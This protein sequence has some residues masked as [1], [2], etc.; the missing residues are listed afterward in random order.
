[1][2]SFY[3]QIYH[4]LRLARELIWSAILLFVAG[5]GVG[6]LVPAVSQPILQQ[7]QEIVS[8]L[9]GR[10]A[11][12]LVVAIFFRNAVAAAIALLAGV[13]FGL[14]PAAAA[15]TNGLLFGAV[16]AIAPGEVW[17]VLPHGIF[18]LPAMFITW[19][20]G[21]WIGLWF[22]GPGRLA[23]LQQRLTIGLRLYLGLILPL[24]GVAALIE[25]AL[26]VLLWWQL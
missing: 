2:R 25:G 10:S 19:G 16:I 1:M 13:A 11:A 14:L 17:K 21:L 7:F 6:L 9:L 4:D 26:A 5:I 8:G 22:S 12:E 15:V 23:R 24:L 18:E 3:Q 20:L